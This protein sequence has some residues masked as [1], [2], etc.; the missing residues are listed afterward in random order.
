MTLRI[1][2]WN[3]NSIKARL[4]TVLEV[5]KTINCDVVCLQEIKCTADGFPWLEIQ[6]AGYNA[7][8]VGQKSYNGVAILSRTSIE[9]EH[10]S[11]PVPD[12]DESAEDDEQ[13][14]YLEVVTGGDKPVR[15][16]SIYLPNGN[17]A[18]GPK[19]D[20]KLSWM[21][22]LQARAEAIF[23]LEEPAVLA[24][25]YNVIPSDT[26]CWDPSVWSGDALALSQTRDAFGQIL[27]CGY[28]E[29]FETV[30][31]RAHA[32]TFWDYQGGAWQKDRGIRIDHLLTTPEA[33][34]R[35]Q[36]VEIFRDA[37]G[38]EKPSDHVPVIATFSF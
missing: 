17:P 29:A 21:R 26:D 12:S 5:L 10:C 8:V 1:A 31:S 33:T 25:D 19:Y 28:C 14:R 23:R 6:D 36:A 22:R 3:V 34:D 15:V 24:G 7:E 11:L 35:L 30:E 37:R 2:T 18:P 9:V 20:Y 27:A 38:M 32:Y 4:P 16:S 13:A